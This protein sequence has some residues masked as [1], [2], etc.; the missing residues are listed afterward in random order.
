MRDFIDW[1]LD[2]AYIRNQH[3]SRCANWLT[4]GLVLGALLVYFGA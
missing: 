2:E 3:L 4:V 1:L